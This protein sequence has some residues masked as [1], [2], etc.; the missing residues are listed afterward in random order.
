MPIYIGDCP[1]ALLIII[2]YTKRIRNCNQINFIEKFLDPSAKISINEIVILIFFILP[3]NIIAN[4]I[5]LLVTKNKSD[6][7]GRK[8]HTYPQ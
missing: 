7:T 4:K 6:T 3:I 8:F 5:P 2:E 1:R